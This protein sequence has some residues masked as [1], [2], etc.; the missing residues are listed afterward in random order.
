[1][2]K[3]SLYAHA[4]KIMN[5]KKDDKETG[6]TPRP[7]DSRSSNRDGSE[8]SQE[9]QSLYSHA[10]KFV[11][12]REEYKPS[13]EYQRLRQRPI[14]QRSVTPSAYEDAAA[15][16]LSGNNAGKAK[17]GNSWD[18]YLELSQKSA[19]TPEEKSEAKA[20]RKNIESVYGAAGKYQQDLL[21]TD[22]PQ[23]VMN[24]YRDLGLKADA[25]TG[26]ATGF[27]DAL[28]VDWL[29]D[30]VADAMH[31]DSPRMQSQLARAKAAQG[32][33]FGVGNVA[34]NLYSML[35]INQLVGA[36]AKAVP[37]SFQA[38][39][40]CPDCHKGRGYL[41]NKGGLFRPHQYADQG[42]MGQAPA[43]CSRILR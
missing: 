13:A 4:Q 32:T 29:S 25:A 1:M 12:K 35:G 39:Q 31:S 23:E 24:V 21:L 17:F 36:G 19:L 6:K 9:K 2:A 5:K 14:Q 42:G 8:A 15:R 30:K 7:S 22:I 10:Q 20:A 27:L 38:P 26:V 34:G 37:C 40:V 33:A 11:T 18:R 43:A 41:R 3:E 16:L 28:G